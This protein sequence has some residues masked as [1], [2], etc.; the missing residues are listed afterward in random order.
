MSF[1]IF[2]IIDIIVVEITY[3]CLIACNKFCCRHS[4]TSLLD[5]LLLL[6]LPLPDQ[7]DGHDARNESTDLLLSTTVIDIWLALGCNGGK[8]A[9]IEKKLL[10]LRTFR[11]KLVRRNQTMDKLMESF[12]DGRKFETLTDEEKDGTQFD[13]GEAY[14]NII[15][16]LEKEFGKHECFNLLTWE[17][18]P[19]STDPTYRQKTVLMS[20]FHYKSG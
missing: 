11:D 6:L 3:R 10:L 18:T 9:K 14:E 20:P 4:P 5:P 17:R 13:A 7:D 2:I 12:N 15:D 19:P 1:I 8:V 16:A